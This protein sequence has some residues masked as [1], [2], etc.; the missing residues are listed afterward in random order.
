MRFDATTGLDLK[1]STPSL[2]NL[3][4]YQPR[5]GASVVRE[6]TGKNTKGRQISAEEE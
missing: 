6:P 3:M 4:P 5:V 2:T 1:T